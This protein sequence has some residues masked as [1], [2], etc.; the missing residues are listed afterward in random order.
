MP[1]IPATQKTE[2]RRIMAQSQL[3]QIIRGAVSWKNPSQKKAGGVAQ[4]ESPEFKF[5]YRKKK[6]KLSGRPLPSHENHL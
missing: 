5:Q 3:G 6:K 4:G 2:I 1:V